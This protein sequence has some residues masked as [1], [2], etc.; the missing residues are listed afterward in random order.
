MKKKTVIP[1]DGT[2]EQEAQL[3]EVLS[4]LKIKKSGLFKEIRQK[5]IQELFDGSR[6]FGFL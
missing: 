3:R 5:S 1:F 6:R 4:K 2:P